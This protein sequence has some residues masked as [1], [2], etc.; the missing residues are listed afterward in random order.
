[1]ATKNTAVKAVKAVKAEPEKP[2]KVTIEFPDGS[3]TTQELF[4][5]QFQPNIAKGFHNSGYQCKI[6]AGYYTGS[7]M[8]IDL[9]KQVKL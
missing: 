9:L 8:I 7:I 4:L 1:M 5:R 3:N 2:L 6:A